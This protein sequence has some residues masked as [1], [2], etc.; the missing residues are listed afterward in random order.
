MNS[1]GEN[2]LH[3]AAKQCDLDSVLFMLALNID[4]NIATHN[5]SRLTA[6]HMCAENGNEMILR[7]LILAGANVNAQSTKGY[8]P[9]SIAAFNDRPIICSI[10]LENNADCS[11]VD[12]IGHN[13]I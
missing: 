6:L 8:T 5:V 2:L 7:T 10:L 11:L 4:V 3:I 12:H 13:G 9:L 1:R